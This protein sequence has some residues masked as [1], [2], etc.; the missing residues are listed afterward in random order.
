MKTRLPDN[1]A[2][3]VLREYRVDG[4]H[5]SGGVRVT[6]VAIVRDTNVFRVVW[7]A[8]CDAYAVF[9]L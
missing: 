9:E 1:L 7:C 5:A 3:R 8:C 4:P 6:S 2:K